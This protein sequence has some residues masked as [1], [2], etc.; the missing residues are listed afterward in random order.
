[1]FTVIITE[2]GGEQ[3]RLDFDKG[4]VTIGRV[5]GNDI[6]LPKGNVSKRHSRVVLKDGK[7]I[8]VDLKSTNGTYVNG[9]KITSPLVIKGSDK[10][11]IGDYILSVDEESIG[12]AA[13]GSQPPRK[14]PPPAP[15]R[16]G[17]LPGPPGDLDSDDDE[18]DALDDDAVEAADDVEEEDLPTGA[19][20][21]QRITGSVP[22]QRSTGAMPA[23]EPAPPVSRPPDLPRPAPAPSALAA[24]A[25]Q[26]GAAPS[27]PPRPVPSAPR[28]SAA[29]PAVGEPGARPAPMPSPN[30][31]ARD[32]AAALARAPLPSPRE[33]VAPPRP[34]PAATPAAPP[35]M[36]EPAIAREP[37][38]APAPERE[39]A[40]APAP[41]REPAREPAR[42]QAPESAP[43]A[44]EPARAPAP[45]PPAFASQRERAPEPAPEPRVQDPL[46][47]KV[48]ELTRDAVDRLWAKLELGR[49][50]VLRL[51]DEEL[52]QKAE[53]AIVDIVEQ[54]DADGQ[55]P[56]EIDQEALI[57]DVLNEALGLGPLEDLLADDDVTEIHVSGADRV[58]VERAGRMSAHDKGFS[59]D[60]AVVQVIERLVAPLGRRVDEATPLVD[61]RLQDGAHLTAAVAPLAVRGPCLTVR[62]LRRA[63][64]ALEDLVAASELSQQMADF[65]GLCVRHRRN[66]VISGGTRSGRTTL[67]AALARTIP[68]GERVISIEDVAELDLQRDQWIA[69]EVRPPDL[70]GAGGVGVGTLLQA[71]LRMRPDR[72]IVGDL[73]NGEAADVLA[74]AGAHEGLLTTVRA[75]SPRDCLQRLETLARQGG[76]IL[77][78]RALAAAVHVVVQLSLHA[79]GTRHVTSISE[80]T[81]EGDGVREI[82]SYTADGGR[83]R[84][85]AA[86]VTPRFVEALEHRGVQVPA[87]LFRS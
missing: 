84:F 63:A 35:P 69:L 27:L 13:S 56:G 25:A 54:L 83:G 33:P 17:P 4:E 15:A 2:K 11:Y 6:I 53:S 9:R 50:E 12:A 40:R 45:E 64:R 60:R 42:A 73:A 20:P 77:P 87:S 24:R 7:F 76:T 71:A 47:Q 32:P 29:M 72:L 82:Y 34:T 41:E 23:V 66:I 55:I 67:L 8:I 49:K 65:L 59:S 39:P 61:V 28:P 44:R 14:A 10:I 79:D 46:A 43:P 78:A 70:A 21:A 31:V 57:K 58:F 48:R 22:A 1:M 5:Q 51:G 52:W 85:Q 80:L 36:R 68:A 26:V 30:V 3:K 38:R 75:E 19:P 62:K 81:G 74:A 18:G 86:G 16:P 37:A